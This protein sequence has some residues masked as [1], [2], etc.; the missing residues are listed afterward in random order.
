MKRETV[1]TCLPAERR[2]QHLKSC[3]I[4]CLMG[5]KL[6]ENQREQVKTLEPGQRVDYLRVHENAN[7]AAALGAELIMRQIFNRESRY[8]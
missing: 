8:E 7:L 1:Q 6:S 2:F 3:Q 4:Y 5:L